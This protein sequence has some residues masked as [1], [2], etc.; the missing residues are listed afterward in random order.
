MK[1]E[2]LTTRRGS[3][4]EGDFNAGQV[5]DVTPTEAKELLKQ[6]LI[7]AIENKTEKAKAPKGEERKKA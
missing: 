2:V 4:P 3:N 6:G 1:V 5:I 7:R